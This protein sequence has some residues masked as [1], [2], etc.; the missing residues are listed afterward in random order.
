VV[1][2]RSVGTTL[3]E[4]LVD[5]EVEDARMCD[6]A[7]QSWLIRCGQPNRSSIE[8]TMSRLAT[9]A[10]DTPIPIP[11]QPAEATATWYDISGGGH[12]SRRVSN[13]RLFLSSV[14]G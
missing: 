10:F 8:P 1:S 12:N 5:G 7:G 13:C 11:K 14:V 3:L 6:A 2:E 9:D 4:Q